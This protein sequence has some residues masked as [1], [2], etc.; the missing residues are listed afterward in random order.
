MPIGGGD[1]KLAARIVTLVVAALLLAAAAAYFLGGP[2]ISGQFEPGVG[3]KSAAV[4]AFVLT[5]VVFV[6]LAIAAGDG[7]L[8][9][10][11]YMLA[12]F[13]GFFLVSWLMIAWIF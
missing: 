6:V 2:A 10:L 4:I 1:G 8:G 3:L 5:L 12:A 7:L 11:Q 13:G 9:E